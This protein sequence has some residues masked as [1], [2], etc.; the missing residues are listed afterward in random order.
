MDT[1]LHLAPF[2]VASNVVSNI[3]S[4]RA[5]NKRPTSNRSHYLLLWIGDEASD[6]NKQKERRRKKVE[7]NL[8]GVEL[9]V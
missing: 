1:R 6:G 3:A 2:R 8:R 7:K 4:N 5:S 9:P